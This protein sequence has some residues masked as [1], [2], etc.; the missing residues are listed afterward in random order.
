M[1]LSEHANKRMSQVLPSDQRSTASSDSDLSDDSDSS[2]VALNGIGDALSQFGRLAIS[3]RQSSTSNLTTRVKA[4]AGRKLQL[5]DFETVALLAVQALYPSAAKSLHRLLSKSMTER[6]ARLSYWR[7]HDKKLRA[8]RRR[9]GPT[10]D[11]ALT[12]A[13]NDGPRVRARNSLPKNPE[14]A[15]AGTQQQRTIYSETV[16]SGV[17]TQLPKEL[18]GVLVQKNR[19]VGGASS[20]QIGEFSYPPEPKLADGKFGGPCEFCRKVL[21]TVRYE[22][23][24]F[25]RLVFRYLCCPR[26]R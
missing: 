10:W 4:F 23:P 21:D 18:E 26:I 9:S 14:R 17:N 7:F 8:D 24:L 12:A 1:P 5:S 13:L 2:C 20:V 16:P 25:W 11:K 15:T 6:H 22:D 3:I 19:R